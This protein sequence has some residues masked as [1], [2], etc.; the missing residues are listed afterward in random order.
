[1]LRADRDQVLM[2][3][4]RGLVREKK[5]K[6]VVQRDGHG[7]NEVCLLQSLLSY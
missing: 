2:S 3:Q 4:I 7:G 1:M 6:G 5:F